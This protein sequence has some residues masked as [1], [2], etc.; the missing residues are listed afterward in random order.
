[1]DFPPA[2]EADGKLSAVRGIAGAVSSEGLRDSAEKPCSVSGLSEEG[3][4]A[5]HL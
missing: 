2:W 1:M 5:A 3:G 4:V